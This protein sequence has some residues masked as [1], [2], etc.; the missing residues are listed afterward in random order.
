MKEFIVGIDEVGR[1]PLAGPLVL[2]L[3]VCEKSLLKIFK[4]IRDSKKLSAKKREEW[5]RKVKSQKSK[6]KSFITSVNNK[7]IDKIGLTKAAKIAV[8]RLLKKANIGL[9]TKIYLDGGL[10]APKQYINQKIIIR[11]DEKI[12]VIAAASIIAKVARD[13]LMRK[14]AKKFPNYGFEFHKGY[15]VKLHYRRIKKYGI[16]PIH[17]KTFLKKFPTK[18][19]LSFAN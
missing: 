15:G 14:M 6:V 16:S 18:R 5:R 9:K 4:G 11:G 2:G 19:R 1:G 8:S 3:V 12:P 10:K 13:G 7:T 17:R